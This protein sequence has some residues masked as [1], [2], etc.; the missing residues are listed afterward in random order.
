MELLNEKKIIPILMCGGSGSR[1]WPMSRKSFPKQFLK[2]NPLSNHSFLQ[3]TYLRLN[4]L[5]NISKPILICNEEHRFIVAEQMREINVNPESIILE[6]FGRNTAPAI[7]LGVI[8]A[9]MISNDSISLILPSDHSIGNIEKFI[10]VIEESIKIAEKGYIISFGVSPT[11][12]ETGYGYI[13]A[14]EQIKLDQLEGVPIRKFTE[15]PNRKK[16]QE[17]IKNKKYLWN[18][19]IFLGKVDTFINEFKEYAPKIFSYCKKSIIESTNDLDFLRI[20][21]E[22]FKHCQEIS[23]D[24]A[25]M[26][27]TK[28]GIVFPLN[29]DWNDLGSWDSIWNISK[30]DKYGNYKRGNVIAKKVENCFFRSE[31]KLIAA[32]DVED[33]VVI[34]TMDAVLITK[35]GSSQRV[36]ELVDLMKSSN[37][38]EGSYHKKVYRP[39]GSY[40]SISEGS[41]WQVKIIEVKTDASL[42]LQK[43]RFRS[44]HWVVVSGIALVEIDSEEKILSKNESIYIPCGSKHRLSNKG[45]EP[46]FLIEVQ[47]GSYLGEDDIIR[48]EDIYKRGVKGD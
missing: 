10:S 16:A 7:A 46:L 29:I 12:A 40:L 31:S 18:S 22:E 34:E 44:E 35:K 17:L 39:W 32:I 20:S 9:K 15:K 43:H 33:L 27:K 26:E 37:I 2:I 4:N 21:K 30:K 14:E 38:K 8:Q 24:I 42:S 11:Y 23:F 5:R 3:D 47:S 36:K 28:L 45:T 25:I 19:G 6:P 48:Y 1:L 41:N 13:E